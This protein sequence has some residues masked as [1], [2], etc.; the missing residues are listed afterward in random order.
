MA[1]IC[2]STIG[3]YVPGSLNLHQHH[4][5]NLRSCTVTGLFGLWIFFFRL[6]AI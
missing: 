5:D 2:Q 3:C 6:W 1:N 4:C